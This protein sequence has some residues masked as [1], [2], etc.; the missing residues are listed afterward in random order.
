MFALHFLLISFS[1]GVENY[2]FLRIKGKYSSDVC[3][4]NQKKAV[5]IF[6]ID[7]FVLAV[8]CPNCG[9]MDVFISEPFCLF[10]CVQFNFCVA[11]TTF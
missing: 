5:C 7:V 6:V 8:K 3:H 9:L 1:P 11:G 10:I 4:R 2:S